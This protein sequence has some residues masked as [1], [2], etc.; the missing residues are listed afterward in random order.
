MYISCFMFFA[1]E[2]LLAIYFT[3]I[4]DYGNDVRQKAN[5]SSF[6]FEFK[7]GHKVAETVW[8]IN[9]T[10]L[11]KELLLSVECSGHS[12]S[13]AKETRALK[14][15]KAVAS[16]WKLTVTKSI[17]EADPLITTQEVAQ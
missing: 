14:M 3:C 4:L 11:A 7:M 6:L 2:L 12:R 16:H 10:H 17:M 8:N 5:L 9:K 13:F 15:R 1:N